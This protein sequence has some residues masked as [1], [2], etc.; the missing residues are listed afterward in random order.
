MDRWHRLGSA[1]VNYSSTQLSRDPESEWIEGKRRTV[2]LGTGLS[3]LAD[4]H[5]A[6]QLISSVV[7]EWPLSTGS[8]SPIGHATGTSP[9]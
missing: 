9:D 5:I 3:P 8:D 1:F 4:R 2:S 7:R 6:G